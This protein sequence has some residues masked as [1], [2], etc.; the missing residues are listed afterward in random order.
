[1]KGIAFFRGHKQSEK[2][3]QMMRNRIGENHYNYKGRDS[4]GKNKSKYSVMLRREK[5]GFSEKLF[6]DKLKEQH[7]KCAICL[8]EFD[9][10][11]FMKKKSAD[12]CHKRN[13][14]RG[15]LCRKCNILLGH[16]NDDVGILEKASVYLT[17]WRDL[18]GKD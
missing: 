14:P 4:S 17:K 12:H 1:M 2:Q 18:C 9:E 7:N 8:E 10:N 3:K 13:I 16:A 11:I 6:E 15:I 5:I